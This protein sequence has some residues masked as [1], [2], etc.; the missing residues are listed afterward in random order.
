MLAFRERAERGAHF[1]PSWICPVCRAA[2]PREMTNDLIRFTKAHQWVKR[3][4]GIANVF[5]AGITE[6]AFRITGRPIVAIDLPAPGEHCQ[7][8]VP[9]GVMEGPRGVLDL[10]APLS[11]TIVAVNEPLLSDPMRLGLDPFGSGWLIR[12][13]CP[14]P[15]EFEGLPDAEAYGPGDDL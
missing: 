8:G 6:Q 1:S 13:S 7:C 9:Y 2:R 15:E 10:V 11:G 12:I 4:E 3:A 5:T 14:S